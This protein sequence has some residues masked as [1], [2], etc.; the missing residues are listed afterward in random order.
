MRAQTVCK[1]CGSKD[2]DYLGNDECF[3]MECNKKRDAK[4][5]FIESPYERTRRAVYATGNR[6]AIENWKATHE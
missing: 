5:I 2:I 3:C 6:W 4:T 1:V